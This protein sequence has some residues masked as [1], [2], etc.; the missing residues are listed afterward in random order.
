MENK[1]WIE[2]DVKNNGEG[3]ENELAGHSP[4]VQEGGRRQGHHQHRHD[5]LLGEGGGGASWQLEGGDR[6]R[7]RDAKKERD[8]RLP[9]TRRAEEGSVDHLPGRVVHHHGHGGAGAV[10][11]YEGNKTLGGKI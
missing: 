5:A 1:T 11:Q 2:K 4:G 8:E 10:R 9:D 7:V 3:G 6:D